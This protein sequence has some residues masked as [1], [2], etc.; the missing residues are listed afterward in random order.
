L[1]EA[2]RLSASLVTLLLPELSEAVEL[3]EAAVSIADV[4]LL[5]APRDFVSKAFVFQSWF[6]F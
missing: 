1:V 4:S 3:A 5:V 6:G 2:A